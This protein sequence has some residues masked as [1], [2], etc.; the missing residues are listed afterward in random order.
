MAITREIK[1]FGIRNLNMDLKTQ[2]MDWAAAY[3]Q[4][5]EFL[6]ILGKDKR[7]EFIFPLTNVEYIK[8]K[9]TDVPEPK[10]AKRAFKKEPLPDQAIEEEADIVDEAEEDA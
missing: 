8:T 7:T 4:G 2:M 5:D 6:V 10:D 9:L 3:I 1:E